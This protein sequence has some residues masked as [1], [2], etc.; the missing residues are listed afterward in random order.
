MSKSF[1]LIII[2]GLFVFGCKKVNDDE[3]INKINNTVNSYNGPLG[4]VEGIVSTDNGT[5]TIGGVKVFVDF[6]GEIF[7]TET[8]SLGYYSLEV[9]IG[10]HSLNLQSGDGQIF[11]NEISINID[12]NQIFQAGFTSLKLAV[13]LAY[14]VGL[15]DD[16]QNIISEL[17]YP[18]TEI[19]QADLGDFN[20]LKEYSTIFLNCGIYEDSLNSD[21][22]SN[23]KRYVESGGNLYVSDWAISTLIGIDT[24]F[25]TP[26]M[27][28]RKSINTH[29]HG[30]PHRISSNC[31][32]REN[33]IFN[34]ELLCS[35]KEGNSEEVSA[36]IISSDLK[37][38]LGKSNISILY[39]LS[40]W[41]VLKHVGSNFEV[42]LRD[43]SQ[44]GPLAVRTFLT[45]PS[46]EEMTFK[47]NE[48][49]VT[50]C[51]IPPGNPTKPQSI[52]ISKS[53][54]DAH[55]QHNDSPGS[56]QR[57]G[58]SIIYTTFHNHAQGEMVSDMKKV[59]Q[60]Y[61]LNM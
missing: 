50:I 24:S 46:T 49:K 31:E 36:E 47:G 12:E 6:N 42:I 59:L 25:V 20:K 14:V 5:T 55:L 45:N 1:F 9:P 35:V 37:I 39:D 16:I 33:G 13:K 26:P 17:G 57:N 58:G 27:A 15:Y 21:V 53:A 2:L 54:L 40:D 38:A 32:D 44:Y 48:D 4:K 34:N 61:I 23:L 28:F 22:Y 56:C 30:I 51:H 41:E 3:L 10:T 29:R 60:F 43:N 18:S 7:Y 8:D 19:S 11:R 52:T